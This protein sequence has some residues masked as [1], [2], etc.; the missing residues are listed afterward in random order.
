MPKIEYAPARKFIRINDED[1][2]LIPIKIY[3]PQPPD[4]KFIDGYGLPPKEQRF[5]LQKVPL[6]LSALQRMKNADGEPLT[7]PQI[8]EQLELRRSHYADEIQWIKKMWYFRLNGYWFFNNGT[9]TYITGKHFYYLN[10]YK[11]DTGLPKYRERD[12]MYWVWIDFCEKDTYDFVNKDKN[13]EAKAGEDGYYEMYDTGRRICFGD[14]YPKYRREGATFKA[15]CNNLETI[16]RKKNCQ[17]GIQSRTDKD[18]STVFTK[19][20]VPAFKKMPFFFK[21]NYSGS[22]DPKKSLEFDEPS[23]TAKKVQNNIAIGLESTID[24]GTGDEG[25]YDGTKLTFFHDDEIG[26]TKKYDVWERHLITKQCLSEDFERTIVGY[27]SKTSTSGEMEGGGGQQFEQLCKMSNFYQRQDNG[28]TYSGLYLGFISTRYGIEYDS[29]GNC[30]DGKEVIEKRRAEKLASGDMKAW[31]ELVR[32]FP[33]YLKECFMTSSQDMGFNIY[34]IEQRL[35]ELKS[36]PMGKRVNLR[37]VNEWDKSSKVI[38]EYDE[39][40][41]FYVSKEFPESGGNPAYMENGVWYPTNGNKYTAGADPFSLSKTEGSR[42]SD[43]GG[44]VFWE[45]DYSIDPDNKDI[46]QWETHRFVCTYLYRPSTTMEYVDD[47]L[48]M[49]QYYGALMAA[50]TNTSLIVERFTEWGFGGYLLY[51][52]DPVSMKIRQT[53]GIWAGA[54][55]KMAEMQSMSDYIERHAHRECHPELLRQCKEIPSVSRLTDYDLL[56]AAGVCRK[57]GE[58]GYRG[59]IIAA[60]QTNDNF[61]V[62]SWLGRGNRI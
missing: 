8:W 4:L 12:M 2:D 57:G 20:L 15:Q 60:Q 16:S 40:G 22:S 46:N 36:K 38:M 17:G 43:G 54:D 19:K 62:T 26:K 56:A 10:Y 21:P 5:R 23:T 30:V 50:E 51:T 58:I 45:R 11:I 1:P 37:R 48:K 53:P 25:F 59:H 39:N 61:D 49:C 33:L 32:Q 29:Y 55:M 18:A 47:M 14:V 7:V 9:P 41:R 24:F 13:G 28:Q 44:C 3:L 52:I 34:K 27:T 35:F 31:A 42:Q 6:K